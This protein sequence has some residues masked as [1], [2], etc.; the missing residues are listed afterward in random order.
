MYRLGRCVRITDVGVMAIAEGC[1][2]LEFL[3]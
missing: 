2:S 1:S 3:R